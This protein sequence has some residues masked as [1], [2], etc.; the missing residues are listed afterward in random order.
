MLRSSGVSWRWFRVENVTAYFPQGRSKWGSLRLPY[1]RFVGVSAKAPKPA[2]EARAL[3][4]SRD[5][6]LMVLST[7]FL[8]FARNDGCGARRKI[9]HAICDRADVLRCCAAAAAHNI[10]PA[11]CH[12]RRNFWGKRFWSLRKSSRRKRIGESCIRIRAH[13]KRRDP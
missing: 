4:G 3:P 2:R 6:K 5:V 1:R 9:A 8:E 11:V 12:P 10:Q 7:G 13:I